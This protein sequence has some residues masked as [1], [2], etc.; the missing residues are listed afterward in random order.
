MSHHSP[1]PADP[2]A[3]VAPKGRGRLS[4]RQLMALVA[5]L[6]IEFG[7]FVAPVAIVMGVATVIVALVARLCGRGAAFAVGGL[8]G[9]LLLPTIWK[10]AW[11]GHR[12]IPIRFCVTDA[13]TGKPI[14]GVRIRLVGSEEPGLVEARTGADGCADVSNR[15]TAWG[16][17]SAFQDRSVVAFDDWWLD[18]LADGYAPAIVSLAESTGTS[19]GPPERIPSPISLT[20]ARARSG[21]DGPLSELAG[22][23]FRADPSAGATLTLGA[24]GRCSFVIHDAGRAGPGIQG[25]ARL[26]RERLVFSHQVPRFFQPTE[27]VPLR[28]GERTYLIDPNE[29]TRQLAAEPRAGPVGEAYL[30]VGDWEKFA[31]PMPALP[32]GLGDPAS[33]RVGTPP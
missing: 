5:I 1:G 30:R 7:V 21:E 11:I 28:W 3:S 8:L 14:G 32:G 31:G 23:Y 29:S 15:F 19:H 4:V 9:L 12:D 22:D 17:S 25:T 2:P 33:G 24:D 27:L 18:L 6:A 26:V 13:G 10:A 16:T 20:L